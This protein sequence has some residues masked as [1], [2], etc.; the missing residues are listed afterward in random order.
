MRPKLKYIFLLTWFF[1]ASCSEEIK[2]SKVIVWSP[3]FEIISTLESS[4]ELEEFER[5]VYALV[6]EKNLSFSSS[7]E[8]DLYKIDIESTSKKL[9]GRWLYHKDGYLIN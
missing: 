5:Q 6:P 4:V 7:L 9:S 1:L 3:K 8:G 2:I